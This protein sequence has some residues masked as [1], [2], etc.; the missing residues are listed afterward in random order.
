[1]HGLDPSSLE[2]TFE[3]FFEQAPF[4]VAIFD[5]S[6]RYLRVN[7]R[8]AE[9]NGVSVEDHIGRTLEEV[10]PQIAAHARRALESSIA[11]RRPQTEATQTHAPGEPAVLDWTYS[12]YPVVEQGKVAGVVAVIWETASASAPEVGQLIEFER[13]LRG[14]AETAGQR[15]EFLAEATTALDSS[16]DLRTTLRTLARIIVP[17]LADLCLVDM[18]T[19][20][21]QE[22]RRLA[23]AHRDPEQ[24]SFVWDMT[25]RW[26]SA[27]ELR[28][29]IR[30]VLAEGATE[31]IPEVTDEV[32]LAAFPNPEHRERVRELGLSSSIIVPIRARGR[33][34]GAITFARTGIGTRFTPAE[35]GLAEELTR[36]AALAVDNARLHTDLRRADRAQR[37]ISEGSR[38]LSESLNWSATIDHLAR[39]MTESLAD[40]CVV[41]APDANGTIRNVAMAA[42]DPRKQELMVEGLRRWPRAHA[43]AYVSP[44]LEDARSTFIVDFDE[45]TQGEFA[46]DA[47][48]L[49]LIRELGISSVAVVPMVARGRP[50]GAISLAMA[51]PDRRFDEDDLRLAQEIGRRAGVAADNARLYEE[52]TRVARTLQRS[53]MPLELPL[54]PGIE[55]AVRF[56][57]AGDG[58]EVGGD[59]YDVFDAGGGTWCAVVGD[60]CGKGAEAAG[61]TALS[62]H[63]V[64]AAARYEESPVG[65]LR[66]LNDEIGRQAP[67]VIFATAALACLRPGEGEGEAEVRIARGGHLPPLVLRVDGSVESLMCPGTLLGTFPEVRLEEGRA[68]LG[69][70]DALVLYTD[71]VTEAGAPDRPLGETGLRAGLAACAGASAETI[72]RRLEDLARDASVG[73]PRDDLAVLVLRYTG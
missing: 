61:L 28:R 8:L 73:L 65:V 48:H 69:P 52:R 46:L 19:G 64:R 34:L 20:R 24:E 53:L 13:A 23:V 38:I 21:G 41:D 17:E 40:I 44:A 1:M 25:R 54:V 18:M 35:V 67:S 33:T 27:P 16:L 26:P 68:T 30:R 55:S 70:G 37:L 6:G 63:T 4:G 7:S 32:L 2:V 57:A 42:S 47:D 58:T 72:A 49:A 51:D 22:I 31:F 45:T 50:V 60:V 43:A 15:A 62:R 56:R 59:F 39:L 14:R 9:I 11:E 71:G 66:T 10:V 3:T 29:G 5:T 36:R 12:C